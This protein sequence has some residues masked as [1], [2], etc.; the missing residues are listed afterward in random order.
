MNLY[1]AFGLAIRSNLSLDGLPPG[2]EGDPVTIEF[3]EGAAPSGPSA[4]RLRWE[5]PYGAW[6]I[7]LTA[8]GGRIVVTR[9]ASLSL[10]DAKTVTLT[11]GIGACLGVKGVPVLHGCA[12]SLDGQAILALGA[13]GHGKSTLAGAA[14][15]AGHALLADDIAALAERDG[16]VWV[17]PG[18]TRLRLHADA[19]AG[20]GWD[21]GALP[22]VFET[23]HLEDKRYIELSAAEGSFSPS[24]RPL[25]AVYVLGERGASEPEIAGLGPA[26]A[27]GHLLGNT[28]GEHMPRAELLPFWARL[29]ERVPVSRVRVP[30]DVAALPRVIEALAADAR[31]P[32]VAGG[33]AR[34]ARRGSTAPAS[35][36][37]A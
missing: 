17:H 27:L 20:L 23:D 16:G 21:P 5:V 26:E 36:A 29:A 13:P 37:S 1:A 6:T 10:A 31:S 9:D 11:A 22:R 15:E 4:R 14:I 18:G 32:R 33:G 8:D 3:V 28:Y 19:A 35:G 7:D 34:E 12:I 2:R 24:P 30:D 25:A